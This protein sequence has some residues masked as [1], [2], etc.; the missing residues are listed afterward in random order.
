MKR[1][2]LLS[3]KNGDGSNLRCAGIRKLPCILEVL[4]YVVVPCII[5]LYCIVWCED[6][7]ICRLM[8]IRNGQISDPAIWIRPD[9]HYPAKSASGRIPCFKPGWI[10]A[11]YCISISQTICGCCLLIVWLM[12]RRQ[13]VLEPAEL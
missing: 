13:S 11:N 5:L 7:A 1:L 8:Y 9:F 3:W 6:T 10:A 2:P 12:L 4:L